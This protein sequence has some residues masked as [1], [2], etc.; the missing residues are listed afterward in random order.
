MVSYIPE[1]SAKQPI[2]AATRRYS[3]APAT[4]GQP[5]NVVKQPSY[6]RNGAVQ[7]IRSR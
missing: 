7:G 4:V 2:E 1:P 6:K 3:V 5:D